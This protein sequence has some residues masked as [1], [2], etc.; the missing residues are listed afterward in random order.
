MICKSFPE[1]YNIYCQS[2]TIFSK[3][4]TAI[5]ANRCPFGNEIAMFRAV[6]ISVVVFTCVL[7]ISNSSL[8]PPETLMWVSA[9]NHPSVEAGMCV[10]CGIL[11]Y[12][13]VVYR[14]NLHISC[15]Q[16]VGIVLS[17][18]RS[19]WISTT[20][21]HIKCHDNAMHTKSLQNCRA[22]ERKHPWLK[23]RNGYSMAMYLTRAS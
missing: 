9:C 21:I 16:I 10:F 18:N 15:W 1:M 6:L 14:R 2:T 13:H 17:T 19:R 20:V 7:V 5:L 8:A 11:S 23:P 3:L 22:K 12:L 4:P